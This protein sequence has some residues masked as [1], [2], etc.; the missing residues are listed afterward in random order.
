MVTE[1]CAYSQKNIHLTLPGNLNLR[2]Q[3]R[4]AALYHWASQPSMKQ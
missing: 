1:S 4:K 3:E 2:P